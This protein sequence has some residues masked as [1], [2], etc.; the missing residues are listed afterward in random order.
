MNYWLVKT[1]SNIDHA[2]LYSL[3]FE[4]VH[5]FLHKKSIKIVRKHIQITLVFKTAYAPNFL[6]LI[7]H[8]EEI[9][10]INKE[11]SDKAIVYV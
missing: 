9:D 7:D 3:Q 10:E 2:L 11:G 5:I 4:H 6:L 8:V 1:S